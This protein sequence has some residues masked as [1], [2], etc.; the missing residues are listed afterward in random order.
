EPR[1]DAIAAEGRRCGDHGCG[2]EGPGRQDRDQLSPISGGG[3]S[4]FLRRVPGGDVMS[5]LI[6][7][8]VGGNLGD[9]LALEQG[10]EGASGVDEVVVEILAA[11]INGADFLF[12]AGWFGVQPQIPA[13]MGA[14]G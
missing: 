6:L 8:A 9:T 2:G 7:K 1:L 14:E 5:R 12:A 10:P 11:P 4:G 3:G 13:A